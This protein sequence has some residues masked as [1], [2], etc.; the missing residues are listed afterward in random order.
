MCA[1]QLGCADVLVWPLGRTSLYNLPFWFK[2]FSPIGHTI[3]PCEASF[4][5]TPTLSHFLGFCS[6]NSYLLFQKTI[7][8]PQCFQLQFIQISLEN[9][10]SFH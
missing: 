3:S 8:S 1:A 4:L 7:L 2:L 5:L 9:T 10:A 6:N